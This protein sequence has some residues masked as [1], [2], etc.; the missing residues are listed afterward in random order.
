MGRVIYDGKAIVP[1]PLC[2]ITKEYLRASDGNVIGKV[3]NISLSNEIVAWC[4]SPTSSGT[5]QTTSTPLPNENIGTSSRLGAILRK[6]TAIRDLFSVDGRTFEIQSLDGSA[7][8]KF[9]PI[10]VSIDFPQ[11]K[12]FDTCPYTITLKANEIYPIE[13]DLPYPSAYLQ[14]ITESWTI[15]TDETPENLSTPRHYKLTHT[16]GA[17]GSR[18]YDVDG[19]LPLEPWQYARD[20]TH[21]KLGFNHA[22]ALSSGV[23]NLPTYY[24]GYNHI[25]SENIDKAGGSYS[26]TEAWIITSGSYIEDFD[27]SVQDSITNSFTNV[28]IKGSIQGLEQRSSNMGLSVSKYTNANAQ[29]TTS[30]GLAFNRAQVYAGRSLN[31][32]PLSTTF[33]VN[34]V[35]GNINYSFEYDNRP[36]R[37][38]TGTKSEKIS[39]TNSYEIDSIAMIPVL[40][41]TRGPVLQELSTRQVCERGLNI[42]LFFP[43]SYIPSGTSI[44]SRIKDYNPRLHSPQS[45]EIASVIAA[46]NPSG[47]AL[48][49]I[50]D[51]ASKSYI[52]S[53]GE[54]WDPSMLQYSLT[55]SWVYE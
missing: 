27:I 17:V 44:S 29:F 41:R 11:G 52:T 1:A 9:N 42:E 38:V 51:L 10:V 4:G 32:E 5:W 45:T 25:R 13:D 19:N 20:Y 16:V 33:S 3:F 15:D 35:A 26:V 14:D 24:S 39:V 54:T 30:S 50:G 37:L 18:F 48:N 23:N 46:A 49:N 21:T 36:S 22:I 40:G 8:I 2:S 6:Q 43:A 12:W 31:L 47:T 34:P 55:V 7:P 28:T 53:R